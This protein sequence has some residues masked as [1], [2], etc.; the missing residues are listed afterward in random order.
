MAEV[1]APSYPMSPCG[2]R[3]RLA[4][5]NFAIFCNGDGPAWAAARPAGPAAPRARAVSGPG[6]ARARRPPPLGEQLVE[7]LVAEEVAVRLGEPGQPYQV[8]VA[9]VAVGVVLPQWR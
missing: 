5:E 2:R 7:G 8:G 4:R 1:S 9:P 3:A 6:A